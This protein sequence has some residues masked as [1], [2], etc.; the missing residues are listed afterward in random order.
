MSSK[1][2][3]KWKKLKSFL[4]FRVPNPHKRPENIHLICYS[5]FY[6]FRKESELSSVENGTYTEKRF[7]PVVKNKNKL[8]L[9]LSPS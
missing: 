7:D 9:K 3:L 1:E 5:C 8:K 4:R 6:P 2:K